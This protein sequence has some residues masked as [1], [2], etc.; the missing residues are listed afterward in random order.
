MG[1]FLGH[2]GMG[3]ERC[4]RMPLFYD[5]E[6]WHFDLLYMI[7]LCPLLDGSSEIKYGKALL[8]NG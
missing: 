6:F 4:G 7:S 8:V 3:G 1:S 2:A 5:E